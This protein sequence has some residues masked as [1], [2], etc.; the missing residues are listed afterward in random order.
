[1]CP[2]PYDYAGPTI[3]PNGQPVGNFTQRSGSAFNGTSPPLAGPQSP[4]PTAPTPA[5]P[6][7]SGAPPGQPGMQPG[8]AAP[9]TT[10]SNTTPIMSSTGSYGAGN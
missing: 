6:P 5:Q 10:V 8:S 3:G 1:M 9:A 2:N 7:A 4:A